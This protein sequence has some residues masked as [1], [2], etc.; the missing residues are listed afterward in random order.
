MARTQHLLLVVL[1]IQIYV[2][3]A[4]SDVSK[5][6]DI[7]KV[8]TAELEVKPEQ[9]AE[10]EVEDTA[11]PQGQRQKRW[12][13][14]GGF[15]F[16]PPISPVYP[17]FVK[18]DES[19]STGVYG[20][21]EDPVSQVFR[22]IQ[23]LARQPPYHPPLPPQFPIYLPV[24]YLPQP[25]NCN[26]QTPLQPDKNNGTTPDINSRFPEMEDKRQNWGYVIDDDEDKDDRIFASRPIDFGSIKPNRTLSRPPPP[27]EHGTVQGDGNGNTNN[28]DA[29]M[30]AT[31]RRPPPPQ[32]VPKTTNDLPTNCD[33]AV[34]SCC[35]RPEIT[36]ECFTTE[37]CPDVSSYGN[38][39]EPSVILRV[40]ERFQR[41]YLQR[42]G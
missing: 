24:L 22:R 4:P 29:S 33:A 19:Q 11:S 21:V 14:F 17:N 13:D 23:N 27:V 25:C 36:F 37:G 35:H 26:P 31:T 38:P 28:I 32:D 3:A 18:R 2:N 34:L 5:L 10:S 40:I 6:E 39:C 7:A 8:E 20:L 16:P 9:L 15:G 30:P 12:Y 42:T 41:F 1:T